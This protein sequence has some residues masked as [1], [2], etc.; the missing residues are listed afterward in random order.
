M[1]NEEWISDDSGLVKVRNNYDPDT[2]VPA[3][4]L[5]QI[6]PGAMAV[7]HDLNELEEWKARKDKSYT[8]QFIH[9]PV[10]P[11]TE[12]EIDR[13][14]N[15]EQLAGIVEAPAEETKEA[16]KP[17]VIAKKG[18]T[19]YHSLL[20]TR[21]ML[22]ELGGNLYYDGPDFRF[23]S[24]HHPSPRESYLQHLAEEYLMRVII[25]NGLLAKKFG[26]S[27]DW[28][29]MAS[30]LKHC[31]TT[32]KSLSATEAW[33]RR[34]KEIIKP[35]VERWNFY[36]AGKNA[37]DTDVPKE[38]RCYFDKYVSLHS[39]EFT[40]QYTRGKC[41]DMVKELLARVEKEPE[42][43]TM[44]HRELLAKGISDRTARQFMKARS[45][46]CRQ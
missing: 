14:A 35:V 19:D 22:S 38:K 46:K 1:E 7:A 25:P 28:K 11:V 23:D 3:G 30:A 20:S 37:D 12:P 39:G 40:K 2:G 6:M 33:E 8:P 4:V 41:Q 15:R 29:L 32:G 31:M 16:P 45:F 26:Y 44:S 42:L 17:T 13:E 5:G 10:V 34:K 36:I 43:K 18:I 21:A 9:P 24:R 27:V